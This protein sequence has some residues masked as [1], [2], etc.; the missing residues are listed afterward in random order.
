M[1]HVCQARSQ[2]GYRNETSSLT[3]VSDETFA[4]LFDVSLN[5]LYSHSTTMGLTLAILW[6]LNQ[7]TATSGG[8]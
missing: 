6:P 7:V 1:M 4:H 2:T 5:S 3:V 8:R